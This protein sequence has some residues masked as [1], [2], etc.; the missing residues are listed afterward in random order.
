MYVIHVCAC[1]YI[2]F[3]CIKLKPIK[4]YVVRIV[5]RYYQKVIFSFSI[6]SCLR[7]TFRRNN[8]KVDVSKKMFRINFLVFKLVLNTL[9]YPIVCF[10]FADLLYTT[11]FQK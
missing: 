4:I 8:E 5:C 9:C 10:Y 2:N 11:K 1:V 3:G 6:R 7:Y